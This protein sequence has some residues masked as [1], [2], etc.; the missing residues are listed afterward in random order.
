MTWK[1]SADIDEKVRGS[2]KARARGDSK[3][4]DLCAMPAHLSEQIT[5]DPGDDE[6]DET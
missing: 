4:G 6:E 5:G 3:F 2:M 1:P